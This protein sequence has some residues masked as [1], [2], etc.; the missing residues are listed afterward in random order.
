MSLGIVVTLVAILGIVFGAV[1]KNMPLVVGSAVGLVL[2]VA[3]W[4]Y[5][6]LNPY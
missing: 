1:R 2:V 5:F 4:V 3:V 6:Y